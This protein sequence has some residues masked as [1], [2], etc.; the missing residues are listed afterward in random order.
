M[1]NFCKSTTTLM[2][3]SKILLSSQQC[4]TVATSQIFSSRRRLLISGC[5]PSLPH[6]LKESPLMHASVRKW[7]VKW[8]KAKALLERA[9]PTPATVLADDLMANAYV[10]LPIPGKIHTFLIIYHFWIKDHKCRTLI[11]VHVIK[12]LVIIHSKLIFAIFLS[13]Y[14]SFQTRETK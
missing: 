10:K 9:L 11:L 6:S 5:G 2:T 12:G 1:N 4:S 7:P 13:T 3:K 14:F 8:M